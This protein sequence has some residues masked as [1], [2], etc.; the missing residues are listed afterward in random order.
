MSKPANSAHKRKEPTSMYRLTPRLRAR[1]PSAAGVIACLALFIS[2]GGSAYALAK[3][4]GSELINRTVSRYK[5]EHKTLTGNEINES[6]LTNVANSQRL[7]GLAASRFARIGT[8]KFTIAALQNGWTGGDYGSAAPGYAE[9]QLGI[10]HLRGSL[11]GGASGTVAFTL[12]H[13]MR[14]AANMWLPAY[15]L[16]FTEGSVEIDTSGDVI[17]TGSNVTGYT[18]LDGISFPAGP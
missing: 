15:T 12:P 14:P 2:L 17:P 1:P 5:L 4:N 3:I 10:V 8:L 6:T 9:D 16:A 7:G 13:G 11:A 18:S